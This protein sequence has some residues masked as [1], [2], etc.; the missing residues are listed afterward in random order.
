L[1]EALAAAEIRADL[2]VDPA[3]LLPSPT[4][5]EVVADPK[6]WQ[7]KKVRFDKV[8]ISSRVAETL[9]QGTLLTIT[10]PAGKVYEPYIEKGRFVFAA[11]RRAA[12]R[13]KKLIRPGTAV[14]GSLVCEIDSASHRE[15]SRIIY[16]PRALV[17]RVIFD[18]DEED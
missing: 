3:D 13:L 16:Y 12:Y 9:R 1:P 17:S 14:R 10:S 2:P 18:S 11:N 4:I 6:K 5:E 7:G 15:G 8:W